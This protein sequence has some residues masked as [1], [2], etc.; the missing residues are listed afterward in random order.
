MG[1][2]STPIP[3]PPPDT[4][5][6]VKIPVIALTEGDTMDVDNECGVEDFAA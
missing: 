3:P 1:F 2:E 4:T 5:S 6:I